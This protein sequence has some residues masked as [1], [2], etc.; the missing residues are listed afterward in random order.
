[1]CPTLC[2]CVLRDLNTRYVCVR[3]LRACIY[4]VSVFCVLEE[5]R[6]LKRV[7]DIEGG[8]LMRQQ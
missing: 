1:M 6:V 5:A 2:S 7:A 8:K 3:T 4:Y